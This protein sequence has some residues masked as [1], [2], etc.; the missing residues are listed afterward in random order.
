MVA[1]PFGFGYFRQVLFSMD[2]SILVT[3]SSPCEH[4]NFDNRLLC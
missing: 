3:S 1:G 4:I 2:S